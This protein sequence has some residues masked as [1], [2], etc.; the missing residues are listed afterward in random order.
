M[1][2][3]FFTAVFL[4]TALTLQIKAQNQAT[5]PQHSSDWTSISNPTP[6]DAYAQKLAEVSELYPNP[7]EDVAHFRFTLQQST[8]LT[9]ALYDLDGKLMQTYRDN[10]LLNPGDYTEDLSLAGLSSG[11]YLLYIFD[12]TERTALKVIKQ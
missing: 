1:E 4:A 11:A 3:K 9:V 6:N 2:T 12:G 7:V 8:Y 10:Q 5:I